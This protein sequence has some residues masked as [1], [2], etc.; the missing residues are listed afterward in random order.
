MFIQ[1]PVHFSQYKPSDRWFIGEVMKHC[2]P[3]GNERIKVRIPNFMDN[4]D[5]VEDLPWVHKMAPSMFGSGDKSY[6][7][8]YMHPLKGSKVLV[9]FPQDN[10]YHGF[11]VGRPIRKDN[12]NAEIVIPICAA[13]WKGKKCDMI[14]CWTDPG[15]NFWANVYRDPKKGYLEVWNGVRQRKHL[16]PGGP[17]E[18]SDCKTKLYQCGITPSKL[19]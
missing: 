10:V 18:T 12:S 19:P 11:Y 4:Y 8:D 9:C 16:P 1:A 6:G 2:D 13:D 15:G 14:H 7:G 5:S 17:I 3:R